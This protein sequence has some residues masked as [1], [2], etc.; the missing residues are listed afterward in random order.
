M[1]RFLIL[2]VTLLLST[3][4]LV[5]APSAS[6][7]TTVCDKYGSMA[8][9][10]GKYV[11]QNNEWGDS[12]QQCLDVSDDGFNV[13]TGY[14]NLAGHPAPAAY[15][16]IYAG[17]HWGNCSTGN[18]LPQQ[19]SSFT[20]PRSSV[21]FTTNGGQWDAS[22][23]IWFDTSPHPSGQNNGEEL[24]I[25]ANHSGPPTPYGKQVGTVWLEG[26]NWAVWYGSQGS[27][28]S[29]NTVSYVREQPTNAITVDI[30]DFTDDS[31]GRGYLQPAWYLTSVQFGFEP[32][33]G[34]PGLA[35]NSFSYTSDGGG[36]GGG[37]GG[38]TSGPIVGQGSG[39]CL[40]I[41]GFGT[42][43]GTPVQLWDCSGAWNQAWKTANGTV[44]NP[45]TGKCLDVAGGSTANGT[46]V[47]LW[48]CNGTG[49]QQWQT[50][51]N[52]TVTNSQSGKCLDAGGSGNGALL[53]IWDCY[54]SGTQPNQVWSLK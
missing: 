22:Y 23:D 54:G 39:R 45:Q 47:R 42:T 27:N 32:W 21:D 9:S 12:I 49:A 25:W 7:G 30:K 43:D 5:V 17:C 44:V 38:G 10:G 19:V 26:A 13:T 15:P 2:L 24:M 3:L 40:D 16:S 20:D 8:V 28:P 46:H 53:Q 18:G 48:T 6:A 4:S 1:K 50:H 31:I 11:V 52:G 33:V 51:P 29:W 41:S 34:G 37:G 36:G 35:V 14:H